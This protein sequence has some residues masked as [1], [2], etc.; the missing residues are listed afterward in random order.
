MGK[1]Q[2]E[3]ELALRIEFDRSLTINHPDRQMIYRRI[4]RHVM[5][6]IALRPVTDRLSKSAVFQSYQVNGRLLIQ[7]RAV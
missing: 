2:I 5:Q 1:L 6:R 3:L 4:G 7:D